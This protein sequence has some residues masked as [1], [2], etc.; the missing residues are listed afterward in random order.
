MVK[1]KS[2]CDE[3]L[4]VSGGALLAVLL[5]VAGFSYSAQPVSF[6]VARG[7]DLHG[8]GVVVQA[9]VTD[10]LKAFY[11]KV[12]YSLSKVR[13]G[14]THVPPVFV[15][16]LP[17][18]MADLSVTDRKSVFMRIV[19]P[20]V[21]RV[22]DR[23]QADH[24]KI[25]RLR[26]KLNQGELAGADHA[27]LKNMFTTYR[28]ENGDIA[29]LLKRVDVIPT[30]LAMAQAIEESGWGTSRFAQHGNSLFGQQTFGG[31]GMMPEDRAQGRTHTVSGFDNLMET[32]W[33]YATNLNRHHAYENFRAMRAQMRAN[34]E[35]LDGY[36]LAG[37]L[38][39]YSERREKYAKSLRAIMQANHLVS[40]RMARLDYAMVE[41]LLAAIETS[42][43]TS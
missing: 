29:E 2:W 20:L 14:Q 17:D 19:L 5:L 25:L 21:L 37:T 43:K 7:G 32:V 1:I 34:G 35:A 22:N 12:D 4:L 38:I 31:D 3:R 6:A 41:Q 8:E 18:N 33:A 15:N 16:S 30:E 26:D 10:P 42:L 9:R 27:W 40:Y 36:Q 11:Q 39:A 13:K 23:L 28:V 24:D